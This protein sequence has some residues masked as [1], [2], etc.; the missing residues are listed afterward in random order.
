MEHT[1]IE[2]LQELFKDTK[3]YIEIR[4]IDQDNNIRQHFLKPKDIKKYEPP[5][6]N[7]Y[8]GVYGRGSK[9]GKASNCTT[10]G[11]LWVD[12]DNLQTSTVEGRAREVKERIRAN[13]LPEPSVLVSSGNGIHSYWLLDRRA[14]GECLE[15]VKVI[16]QATDG[17][18]RA[19]DKARIMRLPDTFNIKDRSN[20]LTC[21]VVEA[22]YS[23]RYPLRAFIDLLGL[24]LDKPKT[25][26]KANEG[27]NIGIKADRPCIDAM[28]RGVSQGE[29]NFT[30][31]RLT[32]WLQIKG[33]TQKHST[34]IM[35]KWNKLNNPP[36]EE[37]KLLNDFHKYWKEDY[38][39]LG[40]GNR[41]LELQQILYKYC[42]RPEC[43][44]SMAIGSI[45]LDNTV[46]YN[47]RLLNE[48]P[49]LTGNDLI[50]YG[51]LTRHQ[52][53][54][55]REKLTQ[56][57]TSRALN[58]PCMSDKTLRGC[59]NI[60]HKTGYIEVKEGNKR[61]GREHLYRAVA[62]GTYGLGYTLITNGAVNG[63]IDKRVTPG[64]FKLYVLLL[65]YAFGKGSCYPSLETL[66]K[67]LRVT[68]QG[69]N[70]LLRGLEKVDYIKRVYVTFNGVEKL[71]IRLLV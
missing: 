71:D 41:N 31:G 58:K 27:I 66:A 55:T 57:I 45:E 60:L 69:I 16:A 37:N 1:S 50:I 13:G 35:L 18:T 21:E 23:L 5:L 63:A 36:E 26:T 67:D 64:E 32:K 29:R 62:Q 4:E 44:F 68:A 40:C 42:N 59:L 14:E 70:Y 52:E 8:F 28:L 43:K 22:D 65:K 17:D 9:R 34:D 11:V 53:G 54:L 33:Y 25:K 7:I 24:E 48:L 47:N 6:Q 56:K 38:K 51:V 3:D 46:K 10:T 15:I 49:K 39:L 19:T 61:E 2:F 12:Y 30:L 20:P